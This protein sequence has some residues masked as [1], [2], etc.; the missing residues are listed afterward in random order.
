MKKNNKIEFNAAIFPIVMT[1]A[2]GKPIKKNSDDEEIVLELIDKSMPDIVID[3]PQG[4]YMLYLQKIAT[5][6]NK[7]ELKLL[8]KYA[9]GIAFTDE[10]YSN[11]LGIIMS[12]IDRKWTQT[13]QQGDIL[14]PF[15]VTVESDASRVI[16]SLF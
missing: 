16:R 7:E 3:L 14:S 15:G 6:N 9:Y 11:L 5:E 12:P 8:E 2:F 4:A 10:D 1:L 13:I